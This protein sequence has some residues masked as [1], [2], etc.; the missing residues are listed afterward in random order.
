[1]TPR[2]FVTFSAFVV[3]LTG[4]TVRSASSEDPTYQI[5]P[6]AKPEELTPANGWPAL[7]SFRTW[8]RSLGG[9]TSNRFSSLTAI[10][11]TNVKDLQP[12]WTYHSDGGKS[13]RWSLQCNPI[14]VDGLL[15]LPTAN[16]EM[17]AIDGATG[18]EVWRFK[19]DGRTRLPGLWGP[20]TSLTDMP[21]RRGLLYWLGDDTA[22]PRVIFAASTWIFALDP[23]TG[24]PIESFGTGGRAEFPTGGTAGGAVWNGILVIPGFAGDVFGYDV[25]TGRQLWR[26]HTIPKPGEFGADTWENQEIGANCWGGMALDESRGIAYVSTGSPKPNFIGSSYLGDN[27]FANCL[28]AL[29]ARTGKRLWHFQEVRHDVWDLDIPAPP[30]L[31]TITREGR[32]IDAIA[33][34][35]KMGNTLLLDRVTGKPIFPFRLRR[36]PDSV[37]PGER[38][39]KYQPDVELPQPFSRQT[40]E[41]GDITERTPEARAFIEKKLEDASMGWFHPLQLHKPT[42]FRGPY[43]GA[44]WTGAAVD[45]RSAHLFVSSN[46][47]GAVITIVHDDDAPT[48]AVPTPGEKLYQQYCA[49]CHRP[50]RQGGIAEAPSL[51]G[52]RH[53]VT[54]ENLMALFK[55]GRGVMPPLPIGSVEQHQLRDFLMSRDRPNPPR[56]PTKPPAYASRGWRWLY[57]HEG[58]PGLKPPWGSLTCLDLNTGKIVW[59]VPLGEHEELTKAGISKTGTLNFGGAMVTATGL[60][61]C[62]GTKDNKIR[63][64]DAATG[65][66]LWAAK[67]PRR[68]S[69]PPMT[70]ELNGRQYIALP[71]TGGGTLQDAT[72]DAYVAFVLPKKASDKRSVPATDE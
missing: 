41:P 66:E 58:Y 60:V 1:M 4:D 3:F 72:G 21:A 47:M 59:Q 27:L 46:E 61:F 63:A 9:P 10:D 71:A 39:A 54:D 13:M 18:K 62:A 49:S 14:I 6:A 25:R 17:A 42:V 11:K 69:G 51:R 50:D 16:N 57:D 22:L 38:T 28:I 43:G 34:V 20:K 32:K 70:Y 33:Q 37:L 64:F 48:A 5:I 29:D 40:F 12:A 36:A 56:D 8:T 30:N 24:I 26:F 65:D 55:D 53:R 2:R 19:P 67:L 45:P 52:L 15:I 35:T 68:G 23:K 31:V 44:N 7:D